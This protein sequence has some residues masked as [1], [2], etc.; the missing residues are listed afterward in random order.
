MCS[1]KL[2]KLATGLVH[3]AVLSR[4]PTFQ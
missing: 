4:T 3:S 1:P 2:K